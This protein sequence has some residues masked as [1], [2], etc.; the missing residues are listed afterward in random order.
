MEKKSEKINNYKLYI[1][2]SMRIF[3]KLYFD[4]FN[5]LEIFKK[6]KNGDSVPEYEILLN[7]VNI[8]WP[9]KQANK[10]FKNYWI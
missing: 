3:P 7:F 10:F 6:L 9:N 4:F 5:L 1:Q 8:F 2:K